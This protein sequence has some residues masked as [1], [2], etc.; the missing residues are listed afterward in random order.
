MTIASECAALITERLRPQR[1][2]I[3]GYEKGAICV[4]LLSDDQVSESRIA[5]FKHVEAKCKAEG[6]RIL[7]VAELDPEIHD[8]ERMIQT[9]HRAFVDPDFDD[10]FPDAAKL[11]FSLSVIRAMD[12]VMVDELYDVY[13]AYQATRTIRV[14]LDPEAVAELAEKLR[15]PGNEAALAALDETGL[16]V[17]VMALVRGG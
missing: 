15:E 2:D 14:T 12:S 13:L 3:V 4:R 16:R 9:V 10:D 1:T 17:L 7:D 8:R 6:V 5:A 11:A